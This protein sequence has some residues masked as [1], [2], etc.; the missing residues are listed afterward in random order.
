LGRLGDRN[1]RNTTVAVKGGSVFSEW[2]R[3]QKLIKKLQKVQKLHAKAKAGEELSNEEKRKASKAPKLKLKLNK[4]DEDVVQ[5][6]GPSA[7]CTM[8]LGELYDSSSDKVSLS[9]EYIQLVHQYPAT[10]R[11]VIF[12]TRRILKAELTR[13]QLMEEC[14]SCKS[15]NAVEA[16]VLKIRGY[17]NDPASFS[18][19]VEKA[20]KEKEALDR[21]KIEEGKR[22][23][24]EARMIRKAKREGMADL[25]FYLRQGAAA[26]TLETVKELKKLSREDQMKLWKEREHSQ[27][28]LAFHL[29]GECPTRGRGCAVW[30]VA[31]ITM[32]TFD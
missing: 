1:E 20:K 30:H 11:T 17:Q 18:F 31:S 9:L 21:K 19:D 24:Y 16:L 10:L 22:K 3:K 5:K 28:C 8:T 12:H 32:T 29:N 23:N 26:P 2:P 25:D 4:I 27:H 13:Y 14:L 6:F 15:V 7:F